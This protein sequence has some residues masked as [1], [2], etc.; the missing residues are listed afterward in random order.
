MAKFFFGFSAESP[1]FVIAT[2]SWHRHELLILMSALAHTFSNFAWYAAAS[3]VLPW[4]RSA[5]AR[6]K[7]LQPLSGSL[8]KSARY[9]CSASGAL[10]NRIRAAPRT[11]RPGI[12]HAG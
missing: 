4:A 10:L 12:I 9:T 8:V 1:H 2:L 6:P 5:W 3:S 7:R 11:C